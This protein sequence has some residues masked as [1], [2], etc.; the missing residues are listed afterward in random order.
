MYYVSSTVLGAE[1]ITVNKTNKA[2][3]SCSLYCSMRRWMISKYTSKI[4]NVLI[5]ISVKEI[6]KAKKKEQGVSILIRVILLI[7]SHLHK[8]LREVRN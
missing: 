3:V 4:N 5:M 1:A 8:D 6:K 7:R 2:L